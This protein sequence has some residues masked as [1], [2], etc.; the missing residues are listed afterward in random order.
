MYRYRLIVFLGWS[1][2][3]P[4]ATL[5]DPRPPRAPLEPPFPLHGAWRVDR[6]VSQTPPPQTL[7]LRPPKRREKKKQSLLQS[8]VCPRFSRFSVDVILNS[9]SITACS[10]PTSH[11]AQQKY[12]CLLITSMVSVQFWVLSEAPHHSSVIVFM[13]HSWKPELEFHGI[14]CVDGQ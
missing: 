1:F 11:G 7:L 14:D 9:P 13:R 2:R 5:L 3:A 4:R 12:P 6:C 8:G 10:G